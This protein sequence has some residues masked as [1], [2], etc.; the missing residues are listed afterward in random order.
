LAATFVTIHQRALVT[1]TKVDTPTRS[2][3]PAGLCSAWRSTSNRMRS[4][5]ASWRE[6]KTIDGP[7]RRF[8]PSMT[9]G[10]SSPNGLSRNPVSGLRCWICVLQRRNWREFSA[11]PLVERRMD[12]RHGS[13]KL[14]S[15][16][17]WSTPSAAGAGRPERSL[18]F[19]LV[20][21]VSAV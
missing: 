19:P 7:A 14:W 4:T 16:T 8:T 11:A 18:S 5:P 20:T 3:S 21:C 17:I 6:P 9:T 1:F 12:H 13:T 15:N 10:R 2:S